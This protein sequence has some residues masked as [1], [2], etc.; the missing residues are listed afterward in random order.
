MYWADDVAV[1]LLAVFVLK[2]KLC[3]DAAGTSLPLPLVSFP[4]RKSLAVAFSSYPTVDLSHAP[5]APPIPSWVSCFSRQPHA[6]SLLFLP[7]S[8]HSPPEEEEAFWL[9]GRLHS[10]GG[11]FRSHSSS[12][13]GLDAHN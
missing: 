2:S 6:F 1:V 5:H 7:M 13:M 8:H 11:L 4:R 10:G 9:A 12:R 3:C